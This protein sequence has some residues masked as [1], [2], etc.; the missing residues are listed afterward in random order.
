ML[1]KLYMPVFQSSWIIETALFYLPLLIHFSVK[2]LDYSLLC[3]VYKFLSHRIDC[4]LPE[5]RKRS[6]KNLFNGTEISFTPHT[7][8]AVNAG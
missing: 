5:G 7:Q 4:D 2:A 1:P 6:F 8:Y 3:I